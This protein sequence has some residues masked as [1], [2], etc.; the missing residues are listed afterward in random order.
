MNDEAAQNRRATAA[1][2]AAAMENLRAGYALDRPDMKALERR[3]N[4]YGPQVDEQITQ[5]LEQL[6]KNPD[7]ITRPREDS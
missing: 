5:Q 2:R 3:A 7:P 1:A 4:A 6:V